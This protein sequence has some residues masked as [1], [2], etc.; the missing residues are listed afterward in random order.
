MKAFISLRYWS[1]FLGFCSFVPLFTLIYLVLDF[2]QWE[3]AHTTDNPFGFIGISILFFFCIPLCFI[4]SVVATF[5]NSVSFRKVPKPRPLKR[6]L[7][8]LAVA[9]F[10]VITISLYFIL[11]ICTL[12]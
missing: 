2:L 4:L 11:G 9:N 8:L 6:T 12:F 5:F 3:K 1:W 7:E 10:F